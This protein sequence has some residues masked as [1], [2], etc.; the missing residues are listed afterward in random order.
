[1]HGSNHRREMVSPGTT[2][3]YKLSGTVSRSICPQSIYNEQGSN[4]GSTV[5]G[6]HISSPLHQ[7][8]G[9]SR[10]LILASLA[11][12]LWEWCLERQIVLEAQ[13]IPGI[14]N[15]EADRESRNF[16]DNNDW[17]LAP[18][19]WGLLEVDLFSTRLSRQLPRFVR[20]LESRSRGR[21][22]QCMGPR[23]EQIPRLRIPNV[24]LGGTLLKTS[25][26]TKCSS[27]GSNS[28]SVENTAL[29]PAP[30]RTEHSTTTTATH[31]H[32]PINEAT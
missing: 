10:S 15:I 11:K 2:P 23:L 24:L 31:Y 12:N 7:Q 13:H 17:K 1:M 20:E 26:N 14:L 21:V 32:G 9:G 29:V 3:S 28:S 22:S 4:G 25:V 5:D 18:Q 8:M 16:V 6:Q 30:L 19:V 27:N